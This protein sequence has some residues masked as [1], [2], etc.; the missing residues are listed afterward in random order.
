MA[1]GTHHGNGNLSKTTGEAAQ[2]SIKLHNFSRG[3][4]PDV[5]GKS[6]NAVSGDAGQVPGGSIGAVYIAR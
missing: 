1:D 3:C 6:L 2:G 4:L 5:G